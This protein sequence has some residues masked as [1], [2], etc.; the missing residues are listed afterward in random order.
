MQLQQL[1][2]VIAIAQS[3][4]MNSVARK[5]FISQSSL[6]VA[7]KELESELGIRIFNRSSKG[8]SLTSDG[9]EFLGYARQVVEQ[10]DLLTDHYTR[11]ST[12][13]GRMSVST[14]H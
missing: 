12:S 11:R 13:Q 10:A 6:S 5:L 8:I 9:V 7:V 1:R 2:Y 3:G 4:S 14:Q